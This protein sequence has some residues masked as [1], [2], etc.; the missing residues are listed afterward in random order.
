MNASSYRL[1]RRCIDSRKVAATNRN[2]VDSPGSPCDLTCAYKPPGCLNGVFIKNH[3]PAETRIHQNLENG[4]KDIHPNQL[5][6][7]PMPSDI[8]RQD[9]HQEEKTDTDGSYSPQH[10]ASTCIGL[11]GARIN[12]LRLLFSTS[13][14]D[15]HRC[16]FCRRVQRCFHCR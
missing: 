3:V 11:V 15:A 8:L 7:K 5:K 10:A 13:H 4:E 2:S 6:I 9:G 16:F 12:L 14:P 1:A